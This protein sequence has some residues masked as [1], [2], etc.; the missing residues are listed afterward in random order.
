MRFLRRNLVWTYGAYA[1]ALVSG[2]VV[3]PI[4]VHALGKAEYGVWTFIGSAVVFLGLLD[5]G[6]HPSVVRFAA[7]ERGRGDP[8]AT[9]AL[10]STALAVYAAVAAV[11]VPLAVVLAWLVPP[12]LGLEGDLVW[13]ARVATLL[14]A[15]G[16]LL[17]FPFGLAQSLLVGQQRFDVIAYGAVASLLLHT[18]LVAGIMTWTGGLVLLGLLSLVAAVVRFAVP[19]LWLPRELPGLRFRR[20]LVTRQRVRELLGF[21]WHNFLMHVAAKVVFS[22]DVIVVGILLGATATALYGVPA[23]LFALVFGAGTAATNLLFPALAELEG[24]GDAERQNALLLRGLRL[25]TALMAVLALPLIAIPDL[26]IRAWV[27]PGF[28]ESTAVAA[29]LGGALLL[30]QPAHVLTQY[31]VARGF[32]RAIALT[33][34]AVVAANVGLSVVLARSV[35]IWGVALST[36]VTEAALV[37]LIVPALVARAGGPPPL[38]LL[39]ASVRPLLAAGAAGLAVLVGLAR[40]LELDTLL[41]LAPVGVLWIAAGGAAVWLLG[42]DGRERAALRERLGTEP[43]QPELASVSEP[44]V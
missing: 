8:E 30:H 44:G 21:S 12:A 26:L 24:R 22:T 28:E 1:T 2:L 37:G 20:A 14:V 31:L 38:A 17:R 39:R 36:V 27:G 35:G 34:I 10:A 4:V 23:K 15:A 5:L 29:L 25:G 16:I 18:A 41:E 32:P 40:T 6:V 9:S 7:L 13:A 11:T 42:L 3:T 33:S 43:S 19:A